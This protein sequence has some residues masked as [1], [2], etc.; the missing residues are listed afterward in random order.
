M[1]GSILLAAAILSA[2]AA[3][4][5]ITPF[6]LKTAMKIAGPA[7]IK[8][9]PAATPAPGSPPVETPGAL[10]PGM[11]VKDPAGAII[12][13]IVQV[14]RGGDGAQTAVLQIDSREVLVPASSL[15]AASGNQVTSRQSRAQLLARPG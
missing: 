3:S 2:G 8:P 12:G 10:E 5:Q 15:L 9:T 7:K 4:A 13:V 6:K 11:V 14:G 1:R